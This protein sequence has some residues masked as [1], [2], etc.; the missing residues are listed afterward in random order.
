MHAIKK[1]FLAALLLIVAGAA[2]AHHSYAMFDL[3]KRATVRGAVHAFEWTNPHVWLWVASE[4][5]ASKSKIY[6]FESVSPGELTRFFGWHKRVLEIGARVEVVYAPLHS[7][8]DGGAL[9]KIRLS[10]GQELQTPLTA[11]PAGAF[12]TKGESR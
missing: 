1:P 2:S 7:G 12:T 5:T 6:A 8:R 9:V 11:V 3:S 10:N 4:D